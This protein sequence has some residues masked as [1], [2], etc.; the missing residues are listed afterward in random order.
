MRRPLRRGPTMIVDTKDRAVVTTPA[1]PDQSIVVGL[2]ADPVVTDT[3]KSESP[4]QAVVVVNHHAF[5]VAVQPLVV[6][7]SG[8]RGALVRTS[9]IDPGGGGDGHVL[10]G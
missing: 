4:N 8:F 10:D 2:A 7:T 3:L 1:E 6:D 9:H 5:A